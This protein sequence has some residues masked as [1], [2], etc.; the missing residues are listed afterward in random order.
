MLTS[1]SFP[2][3][4]SAQADTLPIVSYSANVDLMSRFLW[5]GLEI[6]HAPSIQPGL[7]ATWKS[8]TIGAWGAYKFTGECGQETDFYLSENIDFITI[9]LWNYWNYNDTIAHNF[10]NY[11]EKTTN[12]LLESQIVVSGGETLPFNFLASYFFYGADP[13]KSIYL[14]LK[15]IHKSKTGDLELVAGYQV[16]GTYYAENSGFVN[17]GCTVKKSLPV[18]NRLVMPICLGVIINPASKSA[19]LVA[20]IS[21]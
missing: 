4:L 8:L 17:I 15:Y 6:G 11:K 1:I 12:H 3:S 14:E 21:L 9:A 13:S 19:Y 5:R 20:G 7:S 2:F 18:T 10:F 16:K